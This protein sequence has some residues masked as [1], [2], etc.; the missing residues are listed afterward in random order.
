MASSRDVVTSTTCASALVLGLGEQV[1]GDERRAC[2]LVGDDQHF[3]RARGHVERGAVGVG[4]DDLL[5]RGDP[6]IARAEDLVHLGHRRRAV[7]HRGDGLRAAELE[8]LVD[9]AQPAPRSTAGSAEPSGRGGVHST[10][11]RQPASRAGTASMIAV[12]GSGAVPAGT[13]R[14]TASRAT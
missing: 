1:G 2:R 8:D 10:R 14:P 9:A 11:T 13:Y 5:G 12:E 3:R 4:C 7:G 6:R